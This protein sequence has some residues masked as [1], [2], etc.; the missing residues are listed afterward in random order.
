M[1]GID[2]KQ[3]VLS[4]FVGQGK[5][6]LANVWATACP[7][8]RSELFDLSNFHEAHYL[9][10]AMVIGLTLEL[11]DFSMPDR[12]HVAQFS[13]DHLIE[14]PVLLVDKPLVEQVIGKPVDIIPVTFFYNPEGKLVYLLKGVLTEDIIETVMA[15]KSST[16][17]EAWAKEVPP[18][19]QPQ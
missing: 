8:C 3:Y 6:V 11:T 13:E 18:E 16:Y 4:D 19:Y 17:E 15:R 10:D 5:W 1:T 2:G 7:Y 14:Y 9:D 12:E